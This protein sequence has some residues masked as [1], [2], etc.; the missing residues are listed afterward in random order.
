MDGEDTTY[1]TKCGVDECENTLKDDYHFAELLG[2]YICSECFE[3]DLQYPINLFKITPEKNEKILIGDCVV[4]DEHGDVPD[5]WFWDLFDDLEIRKWVSTDAWRGY[6]E[7]KITKAH[8][9][10]SGWTTGWIDDSVSRKEVF[11]QWLENLLQQNISYHF[12]V[13][14]VISPTSNIFSISIDVY[15]DNE[16]NSKFLLEDID[17]GRSLS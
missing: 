16:E 5:K 9:V 11:N 4:M 7:V 17:L 3:E 2:D 6:A 15:T 12:P 13:Y 1:D 14:V 8:K 10:A